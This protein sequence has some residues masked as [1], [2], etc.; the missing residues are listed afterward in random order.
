L[1][2]VKDSENGEDLTAMN[3]VKKRQ[4]YRCWCR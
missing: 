2:A 3:I 4:L 1:F